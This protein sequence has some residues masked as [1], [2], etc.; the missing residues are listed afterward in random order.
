MSD[1]ANPIGGQLSRVGKFLPDALLEFTET[2]GDPINDTV[3]DGEAPASPDF[4]SNILDLGP[5]AFQGEVVLDGVNVDGTTG[6]ESALIAIIGLDEAGTTQDMLGG[7]LVGQL[8]VTPSSAD[9]TGDNRIRILFRNNFIGVTYPKVR[10]EMTCYG[11]T[12]VVAIGTAY[13]VPLSND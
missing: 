8:G 4:I 9:L 10:I 7:T 11:T 5:G 12:A 13:L 6:D 2:N 1:V 3:T